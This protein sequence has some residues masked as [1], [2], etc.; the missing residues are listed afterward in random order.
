MRKLLLEAVDDAV[1]PPGL[2]RRLGVMD[3]PLEL[4]D[5]PLG[6][7]L[8]A[9]KG[10]Q[11]L[12]EARSRECVEQGLRRSAVAFDD[13]VARHAGDTERVR[14]RPQHALCDGACGRRDRKES[15]C[16]LSCGDVH[17]APPQGEA[18]LGGSFSPALEDRRGAP[19][20]CSHPWLR[21]V[22]DRSET[23]HD[24]LDFGRVGGRMKVFFA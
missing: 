16:T 23:R 2:E 21:R 14:H 11:P 3:A 7:L 9:D 5:A 6:T 10:E 1:E 12:L 15:R 20:L 13:A 18:H 24:A 4:L 17:N 22:T 19:A 8:L